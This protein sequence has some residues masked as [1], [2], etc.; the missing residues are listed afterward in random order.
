MGHKFTNDY[1]FLSRKE[2]LDSLY[3]ALDEENTAYGLDKHSMKAKMLIKKTFSLKEKDEVFFLVGGTQANMTVISFLLK[4][5]EGVIASS[6][7]H[8][9]VHETQ[10]IEGSGHKIILVDSKLGKINAKSVEKA[11]LVNNNEHCSKPKLVYI[12]NP[13][14][15]GTIYKKDELKD[16]RNVCDKYGLYLYI[17][18]ARLSTALTSKNNDVDISYFSEIA[19][20]FYIGGTKNGLL[21][22]EAV[23]LK[24]G[25][26]DY[27]R[28]QIKHKGAMLAKGFV[29]GIQ[30]ERLFKDDLFFEIGRHENKMAELIYEKLDKSLF[31]MPLETNQLFIKVESKYK[32]ELINRFELELWEDLGDHAVLRIVTS[33]M[34]DEN[35]VKELVEC[36]SSIIK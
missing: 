15:Y 5:F 31:T 13:T 35:D 22:G 3:E 11:V 6:S 16:L 10:A 9:N 28:Y 7:A 4:P 17:D 21:F 32:D 30:F 27:F 24:E 36:L 18:G 33:F 19:D 29:L 25:L 20:A 23:V 1:S 34:T 2:I 26:S 14:E 8:I 12:S